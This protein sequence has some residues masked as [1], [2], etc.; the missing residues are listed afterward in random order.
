MYIVLYLVDLFCFKVL[1]LFIF[2]A[3]SAASL[4][5]FQM[6]LLFSMCLSVCLV[7]ILKVKKLLA[8]MK[9]LV[10]KHQDNLS[11]SSFWPI[12]SQNP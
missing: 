1:L 5:D 9:A 12:L 6:I 7:G 8:K 2:F 10:V 3:I 4:V 11:L